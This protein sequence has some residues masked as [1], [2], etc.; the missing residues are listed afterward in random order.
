MTCITHGVVVIGVE[1]HVIEV[2]VDEHN[3]MPG[4]TIVGLPDTAVGE[5]RDRVRAATVNS[6]C[7]WPERRITVALS[8]AA[9]HKRGSTLDL[10]IAVGI[11]AH[12][13]EVPQEAVADLVS[14][15][16][17]S[18][19]GR[20]RAMPGVVVA[21]LAAVRAG[22]K[23]IAVPRANMAEAQLVPELEVIGVTSLRQLIA[24]LKGEPVDSDDEVSAVSA[25]VV[26]DLLP[27][28]QTPIA[29]LADV[30][31][32]ASARM[33]L[34][35]AA[36]GG[37]HM[38]MVGPPGVGKTLLAE[39]L[40]GILPPLDQHA[41][42]EVTA[43]H[44]VAG[45][46]S[47]GAGL[48]TAAPFEAPHHTTTHVAMIGGGGHVPRAGLVSLAHRGVL[49]LDEAPEFNA[50]VLDALR[51]PLESGHVV[52][53]RAGFSLRFPAA[54]QLVLAA[55]PC[56]CGRG[57]VRSQ[58]KCSA[59]ARMR[60]FSRLSGPLLDRIDMRIELQRPSK[61]ELLMDT[62]AE[63]SQTVAARI[64]EARV[65]MSQ[66]LRATPWTI[67]AHVPGPVLRRDYAPD[68]SA[69]TLLSDAMERGAL[70][71]RGADRVLRVAWSIADLQHAHKP[72]ADH[73][74]WALTYREAGSAWR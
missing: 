68:D 62:A 3:G 57:T 34:E 14:I 72:T 30:R 67:N 38:A 69:L 39:R 35:I 10:A 74:A 18:L 52:V 19:D 65:R 27:V 11:L 46:L 25:G 70:S 48:V 55:N 59:A 1:G 54:F 73:L 61:A 24:A 40:P 31:G 13:N 7:Q 32:Q 20:V 22:K 49:F 28:Q 37:H 58:C 23:R 5:A 45:R 51:Q 71:A 12:T 66:R 63:S 8:P 9:L 21:A 2:E 6:G 29:D 56:P 53:S 47:G 33:A 17:L 44:S 64:A 16:E 36:A 60:Y 15:G 50:A 43:I 41:A 42:L 4:T 26:A